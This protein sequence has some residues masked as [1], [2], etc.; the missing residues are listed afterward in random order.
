MKTK[1]YEMEIEWEIRD[2]RYEIKGFRT[3]IS[4]LKVQGSI[5]QA[6]NSAIDF[7]KYLPSWEI[8]RNEIDLNE[9]REGKSCRYYHETN[10]R[11]IL[12]IKEVK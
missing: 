2:T 3:G 9:Y 7:C 5:Q 8:E 10:I 1:T 11:E 6:V 4:K 12:S